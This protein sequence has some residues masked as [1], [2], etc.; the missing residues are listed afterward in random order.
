M[1]CGPE[2]GLPSRDHI[3]T[4]T[5][6]HTVWYAP[7]PVVSIVCATPY[8]LPCQWIFC[9]LPVRFAH[10]HS[11]PNR[12]V[13]TVVVAHITEA[14]GGSGT[15]SSSSSTLRNSIFV[16]F[17]THAHT[18]PLHTHTRSSTQVTTAF[19][20]NRRRFA[21]SFAGPFLL[22][23]LQQS[24]IRRIPSHLPE[25]VILDFG[26]KLSEA[27]SLHFHRG[28]V[29]WYRP[30][31]HIRIHTHMHS[32]KRRT[33]GQWNQFSAILAVSKF[34]SHSLSMCCFFSPPPLPF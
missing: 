19:S 27:D 18:I 17:Y 30:L 32:S 21:T 3:R 15:S 10:A 7:P 25:A 26:I 1:P 24:N 23:I 5:H 2:C 16:F 13:L 12:V 22:N 8:P 31:P 4:C 9:P 34:V 11:L 28:C 20:Q 29:S 6:T 14:N 33:T